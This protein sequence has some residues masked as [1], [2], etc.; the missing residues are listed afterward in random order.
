M[1]R[2]TFMLLTLIALLV[3][4]CGP[5]VG[6]TAES[7]TCALDVPASDH[8]RTAEFQS[9]LDGIV[10][11]GIPGASMVV[12]EESVGVFAAG[13]GRANLSTGEP[14]DA[15]R[16]MRLA[17]M[18]K[19][20]TA[21]AAM[22][23]AERGELDLDARVATILDEEVLD[24]IPNA[25][26]VTTRQL[27][28][29]TSGVPNSSDELSLELARINDRTEAKSPMEVL[30]FIRG[31]DPTFAPGTDWSYSNTGYVIAGLV[32]EEVA[33][34][35]LAQVFA[36]ELF[37][38]MGFAHATLTPAE[39]APPGVA[40]GYHDAYDDGRV[41]DVTDWA[42]GTFSD[43]GISASAYEVALL[44]RE[45]RAG[46]ALITDDTRA[47]MSARREL[48]APGG[49][50]GPFSGYGYG[51]GLEFFDLAGE[52]V[53]IVGHT[54]NKFGAFNMHA[55]TADGRVTMVIMLNGTGGLPGRIARRVLFEDVL[56]L[57]FR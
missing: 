52:D 43:G 32:L 10:A 54:G 55:S 20:F 31:T 34:E 30:E 45:L 37:T 13:A 1:H 42:Q 49:S 15:C 17:S 47:L 41:V 33:S 51:L 28:A 12:L 16:P 2:R 23:L 29:H 14:L 21:A 35:S 57:V 8:P 40:R 4:S 9:F 11:E 22:R 39:P 56:G 38:P 27:L 26:L 6:A 18:T 3:T 36:D 5:D 19:T 25:D 50:E 48:P 7:F 53:T 46:D 44:A 24:D